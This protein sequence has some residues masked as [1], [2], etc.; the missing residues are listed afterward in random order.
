MNAICAHIVAASE[1]F[2]IDLNNKNLELMREMTQEFARKV[3]RGRHALA[4]KALLRDGEKV[5]KKSSKDVN[6]KSQM[7][8]KSQKITKK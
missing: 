2:R 4:E 8:K 3:K 7:N 6:K 1:I 5:Q